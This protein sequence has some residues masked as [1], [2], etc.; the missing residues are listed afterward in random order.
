MKFNLDLSNKSTPVAAVITLSLIAVFVAIVGGYLAYSW[1]VVQYVWNT[2]ITTILYVPSISYWQAAAGSC[3]VSY[4]NRLSSISA[5]DKT[6]KNATFSLL[7][8]PFFL[9]FMVWLLVG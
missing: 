7:L 2:L 5:T 4:F 6:T 8:A 3:V 9:H 1:Y